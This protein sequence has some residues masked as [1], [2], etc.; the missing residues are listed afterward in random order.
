MEACFAQT[1]ERFTSISVNLCK[2]IV[3][4]EELL[5]V[6]EEALLLAQQKKLPLV[7]EED[8]LLVQEFDINLHNLTKIRYKFT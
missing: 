6:Q 7:Q 1:S 2:N 3:Q 8:L 4:E 5:L